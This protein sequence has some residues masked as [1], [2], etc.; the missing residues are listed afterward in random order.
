MS[1]SYMSPSALILVAII[2]APE[3]LQVARVLGWYRIPIRT[4]PRILNVD[5]LAFY[6]P[7]S[8]TDRKWRVEYLAPVLGHELATRI[9]LLREEN[10]HPRADEEYFKIQLGPIQQLVHPIMAGEWKRFTFLYTTGEYFRR[11]KELT[12][13]TVRPGE[14]RRLWK[15]LRERGSQ[16]PAYRAEQENPDDLSLK[17]LSA[18]LGI[19]GSPDSGSVP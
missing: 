2:P 1:M 10:D 15:A 14:R 12:E 8:F 5:Y 16:I 9:E 4:A 11:A 19:L 6:Q 13:L 18:L 3:D 17:V 7:A